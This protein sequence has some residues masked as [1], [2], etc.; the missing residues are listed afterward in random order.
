[1]S[2]TRLADAISQYGREAYLLT[3]SE[4][5][6]HTSSV[7]VDLDGETVT[8][9]LGRSAGRNIATQPNVSLFWPPREP[10]G[11][12]LILNGTARPA[13]PRGDDAMAQITLTKSVFHR[14]GPRD[15]EREGPCT[16]DCKPIRRAG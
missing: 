11:Y 8:C 12:A 3:V 15:E 6:P 13:P 16:A 9:V 7:R 2:E 4:T 5:G 10:G 14:A 1:M